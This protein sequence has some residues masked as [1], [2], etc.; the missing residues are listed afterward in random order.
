MQNALGFIGIVLGCIGLYFTFRTAQINLKANK[1]ERRIAEF[2]DNIAV[3]QSQRQKLASRIE[4]LHNSHKILTKLEDLY[5]QELAEQGQAH[6]NTKKKAQNHV[7]K[8]LET[9]D[10][11]LSPTKAKEAAS[12]DYIL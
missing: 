4:T 3:L 9:E 5:C 10:R 2:R 1:Y 11:S 7:R 6:T 12:T 8:K